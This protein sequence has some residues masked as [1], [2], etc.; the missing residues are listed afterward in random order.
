[1]IK[2]IHQMDGKRG[3]GVG[4]SRRDSICNRYVALNP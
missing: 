3:Q 1:M 2:K 4:K